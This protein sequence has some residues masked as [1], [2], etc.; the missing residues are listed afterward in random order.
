[1]TEAQPMSE[2]ILIVSYIGQTSWNK[3]LPEMGEQHNRLSGI[4]VGDGTVLVAC[5]P[6]ND[7][8]RLRQ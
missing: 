5:K 1:M 6:R 2:N 8:I 3:R 4:S 7:A